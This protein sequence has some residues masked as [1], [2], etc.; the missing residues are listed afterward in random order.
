MTIHPDVDLAG[1]L[2]TLADNR[3]RYIVIGGAAATMHGAPLPDTLDVD[4]TPERSRD[5]ERLLAAALREME[6]RLRLPGEAEGTDIELDERTFRQ[7]TTMTFITKYGPLDLSFRPDGTDG[8]RELV[9][10]SVII[11]DLGIEIPV[12]SL[13]D[14]I[15]S[16]EAAGRQKDAEHLPIL[17]RFL[18]EI[19][20]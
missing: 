7:M 14:I 19:E 15:R 3:V 16:K 11:R 9:K 2:R 18:R 13:E 12:A 8:Y 5:N 4:I 1:I 6:A 17:Y 20:G 10:R